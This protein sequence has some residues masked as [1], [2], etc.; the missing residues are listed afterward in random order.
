LTTAVRAAGVERCRRWRR[1]RRLSCDVRSGEKSQQ[2]CEDPQKRR[3]GAVSVFGLRARLNDHV[4]ALEA[5]C[6]PVL[7][8]IMLFLRTT[9]LSNGVIMARKYSKKASKTVERAMR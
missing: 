1:R 9:L 6:V 5:V 3:H 2:A 7:A 8:W 4:R